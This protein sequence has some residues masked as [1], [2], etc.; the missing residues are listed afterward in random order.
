[1]YKF[2]V[3]L[4]YTHWWGAGG[5][6]RAVLE[7]FRFRGATERKKSQTAEKKREGTLSRKRRH[8]T[9]DKRRFFFGFL[10]LYTPHFTSTE[11]PGALSDARRDFQSPAHSMCCLRSSRHSSAVGT[12][13]DG[14]GR[15][16]ACFL[17]ARPGRLPTLPLPSWSSVTQALG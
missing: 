4:Q 3:E 5:G 2:Q 8:S 6:V 16:I 17:T 1:M 15:I 14:R 11:T 13:S 10:Q 7:A 9:K 12:D